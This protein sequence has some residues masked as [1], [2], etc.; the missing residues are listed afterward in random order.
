[1]FIAYIWLPDQATH[2]QSSRNTRTKTNPTKPAINPSTCKAS[3]A[4]N[5]GT[6][7]CFC[8]CKLDEG[9]RCSIS[10]TQIDP[11]A[12]GHSQKDPD[13]QNNGSRDS[14]LA[15]I[16]SRLPITCKLCI[17]LWNRSLWMGSDE[18]DMPDRHKEPVIEIRF[19]EISWFSLT[20]Q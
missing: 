9:V 4:T 5:H 3:C 13:L 8:F 6:T 17:A 7:S 10:A 12:V 11:A 15:L 1:M 14:T 20:S 18:D 19:L 2:F 16:A